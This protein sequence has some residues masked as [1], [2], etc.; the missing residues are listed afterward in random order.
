MGSEFLQETLDMVAHRLGSERHGQDMVAAGSRVFIAGET[1]VVSGTAISLDASLPSLAAGAGL[2]ASALALIS[3]PKLMTSVVRAFECIAARLVTATTRQLLAG[4]NLAPLSRPVPF[5]AYPFLVFTMFGGLVGAFGHRLRLA[6][7]HRHS[8]RSLS[9]NVR[10]RP[11]K[12]DMIETT[13][14]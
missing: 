1:L 7:G 9:S 5:F 13:R 10:H 11:L 12:T 6:D 4:R 8:G 14:S 2:W 3:A